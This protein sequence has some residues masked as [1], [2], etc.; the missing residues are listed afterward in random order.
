MPLLAALVLAF[1]PGIK[2]PSGNISCFVSRASLHCRVAQASYRSQLQQRCQANAGLD[3][4]GF[5]L[6]TTEKATSTCSGGALYDPRQ[7]APRYTTLAYGKRWH[8]GV[9][10][11]VS[12]ITGL[13]CTAG[14][15]GVFISRQW[16]RG[17]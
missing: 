8:S 15:H 12:R 16:W 2:S 17:W 13:T 10:T 4:H 9:V 3:W 11:C 6:S 1:T 14:T 7:G 5:E